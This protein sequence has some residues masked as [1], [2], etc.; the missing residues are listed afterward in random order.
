MLY[1]VVQSYTEW[2]SVVQT[3]LYGIV[4]GRTELYGVVQSPTEF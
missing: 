4:Q 3:V 1:I 2:Y